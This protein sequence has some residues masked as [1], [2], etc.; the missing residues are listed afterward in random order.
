MEY[1]DSA[2]ASAE[3]FAKMAKEY[4]SRLQK[5]K[6]YS[7][8]KTKIEDLSIQEVFKALD[9]LIWIYDYI[10]KKI[11]T[12]KI[13][14]FFL[15]L[16]K[17]CLSDLNKLKKKLNISIINEKIEFKGLKN[18]VSCLKLSISIE[19]DLIKNLTTFPNTEIDFLSDLINKHLSFIKKLAIL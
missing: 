8:E 13:K 12:K 1:S 4:N 18:F 9:S 6:L 7:F 15:K 2:I 16:E 3:S 11:K 19:A 14:S 5:E 17:E 10:K